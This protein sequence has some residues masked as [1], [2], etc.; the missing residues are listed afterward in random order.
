[1]QLAAVLGFHDADQEEELSRANEHGFGALGNGVVCGRPH[2]DG[3][4]H[5]SPLEAGSGCSPGSQG[6]SMPRGLKDEGQSGKATNKR[7]LAPLTV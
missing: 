7:W 6:E 5:T 4:G 3:A 1:M 2:S